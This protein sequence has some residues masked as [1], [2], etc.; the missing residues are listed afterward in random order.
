MVHRMHVRLAAAAWLAVTLSTAGCT[1]NGARYTVALPNTL[2]LRDAGLARVRVGEVREDRA[3]SGNVERVKA[4]A[5]KVVSP[6]GSYTAYLREALVNEFDHADLL[7]A[8]SP[9]VIDAVLIRNVLGGTV[10]REFAEITARFIVRREG[11]VI[12]ESTKTGHYE[13]D[14]SLAGEVAVPRA[15]ANYRVG[16]QRLIA[17]LIADPDFLEALEAR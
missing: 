10:E 16:V 5:M 11:A 17:A 13:W 1:I 2:A 7:D 14:S 3:A 15:V 9:L 8:N 12:H 4:R 6:Y